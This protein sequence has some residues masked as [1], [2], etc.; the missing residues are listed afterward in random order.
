[1]GSGHPELAPLACD[2]Q[3]PKGPTLRRDPTSAPPVLKC[4]IFLERGV[5]H[6]F[7]PYFHLS[8]APQIGELVLGSLLNANEE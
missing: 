7:V 4:L 1:M 6:F 5:P 2:L 3:C 8:V